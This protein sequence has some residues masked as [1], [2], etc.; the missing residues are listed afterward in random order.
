MI[1]VL[2]ER[3]G[4]RSLIT[5][6]GAAP[7]VHNTQPWR[8]GVGDDGLVVLY[9]DLDRRLTVADPRGRSLH[10][11]CGAALLNLR[12]AL[13]VAG[14]DPVTW[15]LPHSEEPVAPLA[16]VR[17]VPSV[18]PS[19]AERAL[20]EAIAV[21]R[22]NRR[23][24]SGCLVPHPILDELVR[25]ARWEGADLSILE[26]MEDDPLLWWVGTSER[27][28]RAEP[29]YRAEL[30]RWTTATPRE[31]G[32][33]FEA[34]GPT[35][36]RTLA[37]DFSGSGDSGVPGGQVA[38]WEERPQFA[39]LGTRTDGPYGWLRA[40]QALQRVLLTA[41][42]HGVSASFL[43]QP[44]DLRDMRGQGRAGRTRHLQ[45]ILRLGYGTPSPPTP[46]RPVSDL[47]AS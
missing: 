4:T 24:F 29:D 25:A 1:G 26:P 14:Y 34:F 43:N 45:M 18:P 2:D 19:P 7:S 5:A 12:L 8:F 15:L 20:Y 3:P 37:R 11:S 36:G 22:T 44:L 31:D 6:A 13:R 42:L 35:G 33:P 32:I 39:L 38:R 46:R 17:P 30:D 16:V 21:R 40:G 27:R 10:I 9:P 23:P 28:L 41:A 47:L